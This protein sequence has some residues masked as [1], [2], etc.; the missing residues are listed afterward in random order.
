MRRVVPGDDPQVEV[1]D[2]HAGAGARAQTLGR[3]D[4][5]GVVVGEDHRSDRFK[6]RAQGIDRVGQ[7]V[8]V[9]RGS[10]RRSA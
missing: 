3:A 5:I 2:E 4:V 9:S 1:A 8:P 6:A 10:R 7:V